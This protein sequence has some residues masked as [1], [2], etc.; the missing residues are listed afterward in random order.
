[1]SETELYLLRRRWS[2][3]R[4]NMM[5]TIQEPKITLMWSVSSLVPREY[6][7]NGSGVVLSPAAA[8]PSI[9]TDLPC[10]LS[11]VHLIVELHV[12]LA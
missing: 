6:S 8:K 2:P 9:T 4:G 12:V 3:H 7:H 5:S 10:P 11:L 1:M